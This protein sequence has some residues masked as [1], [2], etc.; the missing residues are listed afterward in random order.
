MKNHVFSSMYIIGGMFV[1]ALFLPFTAQA[2]TIEVKTA[3]LT[4]PIPVLRPYMTDSLNMQSQKYEEKDV[5]KE[6]ASLIHRKNIVR[7]EIVKGAALTPLADGGNALRVLHFTLSAPRFIK[8]NLQV[9]T[10]KE[11]KTYVNGKELS[12]S[13]L[14]LLPG[15][16]DVALLS[17][18]SKENKDTFNVAVTG[19]DLNGLSVAGPDDKHPYSMADMMLGNHYR[20]V[21]LS[22]SG[23]YL[24]TVYYDTKDDGSNIFRTVLT[25]M[26]TGRIIR[27]RDEYAAWEW[28]PHR[29]VLYFVRNSTKGRQ[30]V[31]FDPKSGMEAVIADDIPEGGF[32][33]SPK[34]DYLIFSR[35]Q[36]GKN[37]S[38]GLKRLYE[39]DDRQPGWRNRNALYRYD[40]K[41]GQM[42]RL[43]FGVASVWL[44]DI[45]EDARKLLLSFGRMD[46]R[47]TPFSRSTLISMDAYTG[48][49]DTLLADTAFIAD[50]RFSPDGKRLLIKASPGA[51]GGIGS[52]IKEGQIAN[53]F[54][55]RLYLYDIENRSVK[56]LLSGFDPSVGRYEW[57]GNGNIYFKATDG[58]DESLF[59]LNPNNNKLIHFQLPVSYVQG[60]SISTDENTP[61]VV[62]FGQ[63]GERSREMFTCRLN[64]GKPATRKLGEI[65]F[66]EMYKDVLIGSCHDWSFR[67]SRGDTING[68][69]FLPPGFDANKKYP[70][71]VYYYG[72]CTPTA[73]TLEFQYPLQVLAGQ[74]Y[75]VYVCE[76]S[77][78]IG[79]G[80]EFA[81]RHVNTW[82]EG[83]ADD[84]IEGTRNFISEHPFINSGKVGCMGASYG[85]FMTQYLQ[86]RT[87]IF[88]TAISHAGISN[89]A[90]YW[91]GG[92]WGYTY[93]EVAQYGSYPWNNS[94]LYVKQS[95]LFNAEKIHTPLLLLHGTADTNVPTNE[96]QQLFTALRI[97]GRPVSY[98]QVDG[99]NHVIV[100]HKKRL[101]WQNAI[102]AWFAHWLK[103]EPEWWK[104]LYPEDD[105]G[106]KKK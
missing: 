102:F 10:L 5:L 7:N 32:T 97:L 79:Y 41:T 89:I 93:G 62:F 92:Y 34:V 29:D 21:A 99:E 70:L 105:F 39:P 76:P 33:I 44:S 95:P 104:E 48:K 77:G 22:P 90:S 55:Y 63:T 50:A 96:S 60:Y 42:Q 59:S 68:F 3:M 83:S 16:T 51:F 35:N 25:E 75:V 101:V 27:S 24:V 47:N 43:T 65:D 2:D 106:M 88:T 61:Q 26:S 1:S 11:Y 73:K 85:G 13:D 4:D 37:E 57:V 54:D 78:A 82:G 98:I 15:H 58:C 64:S 84:I 28:L 6:N 36:T 53:G 40:L 8:A 94:E 52:E 12:G 30:L 91:G 31:T 23:K 74:G 18:S 81:A 56:P 46:M 49:V 86:T 67:S 100:N 80:Q 87:D 66:D 19:K 69:Y 14:L 17:L 71:I 103:D 38:N 9:K 45:S 20:N 72:G